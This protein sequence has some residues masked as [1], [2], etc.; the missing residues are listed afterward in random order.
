MVTECQPVMPVR[1]LGLA[2]FER[3]FEVVSQNARPPVARVTSRAPRQKDS[4]R[5]SQLLMTTH[6]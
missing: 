5:P 6:V 1:L 3:P 4:P 2:A